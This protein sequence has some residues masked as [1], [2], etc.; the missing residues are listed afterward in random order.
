MSDN[1]KIKHKITTKHSGGEAP[2]RIY[3]S[4]VRQA[5]LMTLQSE[6]VDDLCVVNVLITND[7]GIRKYNL[8]YRDIDKETDVLSFPMQTFKQPGWSGLDSAEL[9]ED[10]G[11]LPLG[12]IVISSETVKR[13]ASEY[14]NTIEHE[15]TYMIIHSTLHLLGYSHENESNERTMHN[16]KKQLMREM[17][18]M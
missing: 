7:D 3:R 12:D 15:T 6:N 4:L 5:V 11:E 1:N 8:K 2:E 18:Y 16:K 10:T 13:H 9:D 14:G 17:G